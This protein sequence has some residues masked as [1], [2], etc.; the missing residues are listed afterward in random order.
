MRDL[1]GPALRTGRYESLRK[2]AVFSIALTLFQAG[3]IGQTA[4]R[5]ISAADFDSWRSIQGT[6]ISRDGNYVAYVLQP[7]DGDG[8]FVVRSTSTETE[9]RIPRGY[10]PPTPPPDPAD[11]AA[12]AAFQAMGRLLR[13]TFSADSKY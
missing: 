10:R 13:P 11:P 3:V 6:Q 5:P 7:Q 12:T 2:L 9:R 1:P 4:K 8:E